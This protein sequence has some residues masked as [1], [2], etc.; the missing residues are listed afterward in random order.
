MWSNISF[1]ILSEYKKDPLKKCLLVYDKLSH[2][3]RIIEDHY[4]SVKIW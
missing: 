2:E 3:Q 4:A 1:K